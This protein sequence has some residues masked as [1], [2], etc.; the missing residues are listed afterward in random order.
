MARLTFPSDRAVYITGAVGTP[1]RSAAGLIATIWADSA[2]TVLADVQNLDGTANSAATFVVDANS[3][4][5]LFLGPAS[6]ADSLFCSVNGG[7]VVPIYA[8]A[9]ADLV[10]ALAVETARATAAEALKA[11]LAAPALTGAATLG[12]VAIETTAGSAAKVATETSRATTA[13][14]LLIPLAQKGAASGVA[15]LNGSGLVPRAQL[16]NIT[17][18][19]AQTVANQAAMLALV[20]PDA[21][22][23]LVVFRTD[24]PASVW[25]LNPGLNAAVLG[26][27]IETIYD[28]S[29]AASAALATAESFA[30]SAVAT[31]QSRAVAAEALKAPLASPS[32]TGAATLGGVAIE[33][34]AG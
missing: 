7:P 27:W 13:E 26:N 20:P 4:L 11:P 22:T 17:A 24:V 18:T 10:A 23:M 32:L 34:T 15:S 5:P 31:E 9:S 29:G 1:L 25:Y 30:T 28:A 19:L 14:A 33:T 2:G 3:E 6:G 8:L 16:P 12:G 21:D